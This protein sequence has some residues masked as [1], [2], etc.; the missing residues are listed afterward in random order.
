MTGGGAATVSRPR[1]VGQI[2]PTVFRLSP[3]CTTGTIDRPR[4]LRPPGQGRGSF[5]VFQPRRTP[6]NVEHIAPGTED[7]A[8]PFDRSRV[9]AC[10]R[11]GAGIGG[12]RPR[13]A[14]R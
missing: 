9:A 10:S 8:G 6:T 2:G 11:A 5:H 3:G 13:A 12:Q 7:D 4:A 1:T 14:R